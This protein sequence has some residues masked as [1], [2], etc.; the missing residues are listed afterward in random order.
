MLEMGDCD[1]LSFHL[2]H[3]LDDIHEILTKNTLGTYI[4][5]FY[6]D[7]IENAF[8]KTKYFLIR[9]FFGGLIAVYHLNTEHLVKYNLMKRGYFYL[10]SFLSMWKSIPLC[11]FQVLAHKKQ[12]FGFDTSQTAPHLLGYMMS[13]DD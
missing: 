1:G 2:A 4:N 12:K 9:G 8:K 7:R 5:Q 10:S 3:L 11:D 6:I 13:L